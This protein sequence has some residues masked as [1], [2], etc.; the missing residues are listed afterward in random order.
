[1]ESKFPV[2]M[3]IYMVCSLQLQSFRKFCWAV[4][5]ELRWKIKPQDWLTDGRVKNIIH[6]AT[7]CVGYK[8][9]G[10]PKLKGSWSSGSGSC[11]R[12][13]LYDENVDHFFKKDNVFNSLRQKIGKLG[14]K[15]MICKYQ[16][17][18]D[19]CSYMKQLLSL[20]FCFIL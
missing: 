4:S 10:L 12:T 20:N 3:H 5:E 18:Q 14:I 9:K 15:G 7:R 17:L 16:V 13:W 8:K 1:M 6:S 19:D 11:I 2:D